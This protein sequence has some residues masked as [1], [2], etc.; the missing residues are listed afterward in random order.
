MEQSAN[1]GI[2][3]SWSKKLFEGEFR[4]YVSFS[5]LLCLVLALAYWPV[6]GMQYTMKWDIMDQFFPYRLFMS[7]AYH[8]GVFPF[9]NPYINFGYP[10]YADPQ[11]AA[12]YPITFLLVRC[13]HYNVFLLNAEWM[14]HLFIAGLGMFYMLRVLRYSLFTTVVIACMFPLCGM[15]VSNAQHLTW[16]IS[17]AWLPWINGAYISMLER[18]RKQDALLCG[19]ASAMCL[20]GGYPIF[21]VLQAYLMAFLLVKKIA[22]SLVSAKG[23]AWGKTIALNC[24]VVLVFCLVSLPYVVA[25]LKVK[26]LIT[27]GSAL[28]LELACSNAFTPHCYLS[29]LSSFAAV[30]DGNWFHTDIAMNNAYCGVLLL[31]LLLFWPWVKKSTYSGTFVLF[32]LLCMAAALGALIPFRKFLYYY[33]PLMNMFRNAAIF[34]AFGIMALLLLFAD[35]LNWLEAL[36]TEKLKRVARYFLFIIIG[37]AAICACL[38]VKK[39]AQLPQSFSLAAWNGYNAH[40]DV[41]SHWATQ[42]LLQLLLFLVVTTSLFF[43]KNKQIRSLSLA[44]CILF[45][46]II[47]VNLNAPATIISDV[48]LAVFNEKMKVLPRDFP[49]PGKQLLN[50]VTHV[51]NGSLVPAWYNNS[52]YKKQIAL[53]GFNSFYQKSYDDFMDSPFKEGVLNNHL[54]YLSNFDTIDAKGSLFCLNRDSCGTVQIE[55]KY[56]NEFIAHIRVIRPC[57]L[58]FLQSAFPGWRACVNERAAPPIVKCNINFQS[59]QFEKECYATVRFF[60]ITSSAVYMRNFSFLIVGLVLILLFIRKV[61]V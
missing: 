50:S 11:S 15:F 14:L 21:F 46:M 60:Y 35:L 24:I 7:D 47:A 33:I 2:F 32:G 36:N 28:S 58:V 23:V 29:L 12:F 61:L 51:G 42:I 20:L 10:Y 31:P 43:I 18:E 53:D 6:M 9:W 27:R 19:L 52:M 44:L 30:G 22:A 54:F 59:L 17:L 55:S 40:F 48:P 56:P 13:F 16:V 26:S 41:A 37:L 1:K 57:R 5:V 38:F 8:Q 45:D 49:N 25:F 34:R 3:S 4:A 39:S